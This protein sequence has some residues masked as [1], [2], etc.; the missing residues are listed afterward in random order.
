ME[1]SIL[2]FLNLHI[3]QLTVINA[4][5]GLRRKWQSF[6]EHKE[7][8]T[9][10]PRWMLWFLFLECDPGFYGDNCSLT[11]PTNYYGLRCGNKCHCSSEKYCD[12]VRGC[13]CKQSS[14][15]CTEEGKNYDN[16]F[17]RKEQTLSN[18]I[19]TQYV[20]IFFIGDTKHVISNEFI[21][22]YIQCKYFTIE[23]L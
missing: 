20:F 3:F 10:L 12:H 5:W 14:I 13:L 22:K 7:W 19:T 2:S 21:S 8:M 17:I 16:G 23:C 1:T 9:T 6:I 15:N 18:H 11:C 4:C